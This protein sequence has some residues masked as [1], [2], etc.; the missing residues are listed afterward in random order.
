V[1]AEELTVREENYMFLVADWGRPADLEK[2]LSLRLPWK[3]WAKSFMKAI[4]FESLTSICWISKKN[5]IRNGAI[6]LS[7][8]FGAP[9]SAF[10]LLIAK[11]SLNWSDVAISSLDKLG[12]SPYKLEVRCSLI[13]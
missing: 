10:C 7:N 6:L 9:P 5:Y 12:K 1:P 4:I 11:N 8:S 2:E 13:S 3:V